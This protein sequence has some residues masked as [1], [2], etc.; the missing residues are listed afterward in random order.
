MGIGNTT[1]ASALVAAL[2]GAAPEEVIGPGTGVDAAGPRPQGARDR[3]GARRQSPG[4]GDP[5]GVLAAVGASRSRA[6]P[7]SSSRRGRAH[8]GRARRLH[9]RRRGAGRRPAR[10]GGR[11]FLL[12]SHRSAEPGHAVILDALGSSP[13]LDLG[14]RLGEG[15]GAA[16][17]IGL[18]RAAVEVLRRWRRSSRPA[19]RG[20]PSDACRRRR[21]DLLV[22]APPGAI[23]TPP[24]PR[25]FAGVASGARGWRVLASPW[26]IRPAASSRC[27]RRPGASCHSC[28]V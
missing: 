4:P 25:R 21:W 8:P 23:R 1:A 16:L 10:A 14:M 12:A 19:C 20:V 3:A 7:G 24:A 13:Y 18:A 26:S 27:Q 17:G 2:T 28:P 6:S 5:L 22:A 11:R 15:T 9:R